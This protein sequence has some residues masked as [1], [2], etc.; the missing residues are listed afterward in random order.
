LL[1]RYNYMVPIL[2]MFFE[3]WRT[4]SKAAATA[5]ALSSS[6]RRKLSNPLLTRRVAFTTGT[7]QSA[8]V[9]AT[10]NV[11]SNL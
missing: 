2:V 1:G 11:A 5:V 8:S 3:L 7:T 4:S 9:P 10:L 6:A